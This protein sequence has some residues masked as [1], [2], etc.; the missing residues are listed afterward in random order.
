[1]TTYGLDELDRAITDSEDHGFVKV[2]TSPNT[3]RIIGVTIVGENAPEIMSEFVLAI[4]HKL[5]LNKILSTTH[6]YP[7]FSE[8]NKYVSGEWK[9]KH[10]SK[11]ILKILKTYHRIMRK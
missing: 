11:T 8:A 9:R 2:L 10:A 3:D 6:I 4:K 1:M 5:G 7:T